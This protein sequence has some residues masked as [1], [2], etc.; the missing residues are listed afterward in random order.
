MVFLP[1]AQNCRHKAS[2]HWG[3]L[4]ERL[5]DAQT[6]EERE[7]EKESKSEASICVQASGHV[8]LASPLLSSSLLSSPLLSSPESVYFYVTPY[9]VHFPS[10][11][12]GILICVTLLP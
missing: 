11:M 10:I 3:D 12:P 5:R 8:L 7:G 2:F 1:L 9:F 4:A 6:A